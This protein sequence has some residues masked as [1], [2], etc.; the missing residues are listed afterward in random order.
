MRKLVCTILMVA[1]AIAA[2][3][4]QA[5]TAALKYDTKTHKVLKPATSSSVTSDLDWADLANMSG[6]SIIGV[7]VDPISGKKLSWNLTGLT[8]DRA[9]FAP[10]ANSTLVVSFTQG[11]LIATPQAPAIVKG[12]GSDGTVK[13]GYPDSSVSVIAADKNNYT[14][15]GG[16]GYYQRWSTTGGP[17]NVTGLN[18]NQRDG[19][20]FEIT[21]VNAG[22]GVNVVIKNESASSV[23]ANRFHCRTGADVTLA[24]DQS[25]MVTYDE[26]LSRF[27]VRPNF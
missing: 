5:G 7:F 6:L 3:H 2:A 24:P 1:A 22:G 10:D 8:A 25:A 17:W 19:M 4:G 14:P 13:F 16:T 18:V 26:T 9:A 20:T 15:A 12:V 11:I 23:A 21:N 27:R